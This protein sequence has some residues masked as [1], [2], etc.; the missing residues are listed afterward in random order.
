MI[1]RAQRRKALK[2]IEQAEHGLSILR[3]KATGRLDAASLQDAADHCKMLIDIIGDAQDVFYGA[4][5]AT[6][7]TCSTCK[8]KGRTLAA[9]QHRTGCPR[10]GFVCTTVDVARPRPGA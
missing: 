3:N 4:L 7:V 5:N 10:G 6:M 8:H 9:I 1:T 2:R